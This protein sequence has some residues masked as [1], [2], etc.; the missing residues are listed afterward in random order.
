VTSDEQA[1]YETRNP[2]LVVTFALRFTSF[3]YRPLL[4]RHLSLVT[5]LSSLVFEKDLMLMHRKRVHSLVFIA[6]AVGFLTACSSQGKRPVEAGPVIS[7]VQTEIV[8]L[9]SAPQLYQAVGAIHSANTAILAAQIAGTVREIR[10]QPGDHV[11]RGQLLAL[12]DDRSAQ[13]QAQ[14]AE[15]GVNEAVQGE[16][17]IEQALKAA[18]ADRKFAEATYNRYKALL[19]KN[20]L[21]RQEFDG[22]EARYQSALANERSIEAR[23]EQV[24]ARQQQAR[25]QQDSAQTYLSYARI[26]APLDGIVTAKS[27]DAGT[28][29]L[30][31]MPVLTVEE[32]A[33]YR[34]EASLPEQYLPTAKVGDTVAVST[35]HGQFEGRVAEVVPAADV[36]SHTFLVKIDLPPNCSCRSGEYGQ[37][38]FPIG[39]AKGL[40]VP[41]SAVVEHGELQGI[42]VVTPE[43]RVEYRLVKTGKTLGNQVEILSGLAA[44]EKVA[45]SQIDR[46]RDGARVEGQ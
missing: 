30:P 22:A 41:S 45:V 46:L 9:E 23:K 13:A 28:V 15:A 40:V 5:A 43:G 33:R 44:G 39:E 32:T 7:G 34:L 3:D 36:A 6:I 25:S 8:R 29:V 24:M 38:S 10:V 21:S 42:F 35:E 27:V 26:V 1:K 20:S 16:A 31:G 4:A 37:A 19:A 2:K 17:E 11:K 14:G 12:L 18:T